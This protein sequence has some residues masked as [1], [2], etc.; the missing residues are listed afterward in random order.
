M[1]RPER[2][3]FISTEMV[4]CEEGML[5]LCQRPERASFISTKC[6]PSEYGK[7]L[8]RV[9]AL[10]GLLSFLRIFQCLTRR[11]SCRCQRPE[12]ASFIS[13]NLL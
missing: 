4:E 9:N 10:N 1:Q 6:V 2:A 5:I 3:S 7:S 12:R 8:C 11:S 13:T